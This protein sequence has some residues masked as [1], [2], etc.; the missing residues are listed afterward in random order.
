MWVKIWSLP[1]VL[2]VLQDGEDEEEDIDRLVSFHKMTIARSSSSL[3]S[4]KV[5]T[6]LTFFRTRVDFSERVSLNSGL[7]KFLKQSCWF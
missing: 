4:S 6:F 2:P 3:Q 5:K 7:L 1:N